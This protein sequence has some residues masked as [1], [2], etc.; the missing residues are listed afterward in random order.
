MFAVRA[1]CGNTEMQ[2]FKRYVVLLISRFHMEMTTSNSGWM[3][4]ASPIPRRSG[5]GI[6]RIQ[7]LW[8]LIGHT[9][10]R[11]INDWIF[12]VAT[13]IRRLLASGGSPGYDS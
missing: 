11:W 8:T 7:V 9:V 12:S 6:P 1:D 5:S 2:D 13:T 4:F 3:R 10:S